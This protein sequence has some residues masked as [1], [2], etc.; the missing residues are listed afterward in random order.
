[1]IDGA[2][3]DETVFKF[4]A[5]FVAACGG[6]A[7]AVWSLITASHVVTVYCQLSRT[8]YSRLKVYTTVHRCLIQLI[9][10]EANRTAVL[11][12][13]SAAANANHP[14]FVF[15]CPFFG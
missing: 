1:M 5:L 2:D 13:H 14:D 3:V 11:R 7:V 12:L 9:S 4:I 8:A 10:A 6:A 15:V